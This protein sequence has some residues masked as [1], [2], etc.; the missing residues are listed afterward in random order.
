MVATCHN[1]NS[2][3]CLWRGNPSVVDGGTISVFSHNTCIINLWYKWKYIE[4]KI[5]IWAWSKMVF[6]PYF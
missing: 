6:N 3:T 4:Q 5:K 2:T 1:F